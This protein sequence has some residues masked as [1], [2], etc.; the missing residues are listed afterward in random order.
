MQ[1]GDSRVSHGQKNGHDRPVGNHT[2]VAGKGQQPAVDSQVSIYQE[3][4]FLGGNT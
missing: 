2:P 3:T 4:V 1:F